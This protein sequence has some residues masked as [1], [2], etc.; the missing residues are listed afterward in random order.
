MEQQPGQ[1][2]RTNIKRI[3]KYITD[4]ITGWGFD[5]YI[6][7]SRTTR[8]RYLEFSIGNRQSFIIRISDHPTGKYWKYDYD[9]YTNQPRRDAINYLT[10]INIFEQRLFRGKT[11]QGRLA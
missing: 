5:V 8:S 3:T 6:S 7:P 11:K 4:K 1:T 9:V 10:L 2:L